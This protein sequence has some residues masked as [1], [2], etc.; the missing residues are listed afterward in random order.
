MDTFNSNLKDKSGSGIADLIGNWHEVQ[1]T[2][3]SLVEDMFS[4]CEEVG[5]SDV[6]ACARSVFTALGKD[7]DGASELEVVS[8]RTSVNNSINTFLRERE[9]LALYRQ[10]LFAESPDLFL[11]PES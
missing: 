5:S 9:K 8:I 4:D 6:T 2:I 11:N 10:K 3:E 7:P 1:T